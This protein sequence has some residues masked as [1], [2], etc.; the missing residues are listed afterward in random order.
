MEGSKA[1][2]TRATNALS[3]VE[4]PLQTF[5][6]STLDGGVMLAARPGRFI[7]ME[8]AYTEEAGIRKCRFT[9]S[10]SRPCRAAALL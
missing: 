2:P 6:T 9:H 4:I 5:L 1:V 8:K 3:L 7:P 10:M